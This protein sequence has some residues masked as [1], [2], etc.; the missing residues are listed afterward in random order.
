[1]S[2]EKIKKNY[3]DTS[4]IWSIG[5]IYYIMMTHQRPF[6]YDNK[7]EYFKAICDE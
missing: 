5:I 7:T 3:N 4:D 1:M 2:P 6:A